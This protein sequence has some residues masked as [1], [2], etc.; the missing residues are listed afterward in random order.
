MITFFFNVKI[1]HIFTLI[2]T[3][4]TLCSS[5]DSSTVEGTVSFLKSNGKRHL[6]ITTLDQNEVLIERWIRSLLRNSKINDVY[7]KFTRIS[8]HLDKNMVTKEKGIDFSR[9]SV[10]IIA[11]AI[12]SSNW[13]N[14]ID[15]LINTEIESAT[16]VFPSEL[17]HK[18]RN[19]F[20]F[21]LKS[22]NKSSYFYW[23]YPI[24]KKSS[25][26]SF[27]RVLT[28]DNI[29]QVIVDGVKFNQFGHIKEDYDLHGLKVLSTTVAWPP[30]IY[31]NEECKQQKFDPN[32]CKPYGHLVDVLN[33]ISRVAN[34][35]WECHSD[36]FD[37]YGTAP[38]SGPA[39]TSGEWGG[40]V[41]NVFR[42]EYHFSMSTWVWNEE[43]QDMFD[44]ATIL[45]DQP[46][47]A[48]T[49]KEQNID[50]TLFTRPFSR[51][52]WLIIGLTITLLLSILFIPLM[53]S[54]KFEKSN[55]YRLIQSIAFLFFMLIEIYYGGAL[56]MFFASSPV[57]PFKTISDVIRGYPGWQ[58][59]ML[60]GN[61][62]YYVY[63]V[64][65]GDPDY[66]AFWERVKNKPEDTVVNSIDEGMN[67][68]LNGFNVVHATEGVIKGW[69]TNNAEKGKKI[70]LFGRG[71]PSFYT[72]ITTNNSPLSRI[73]GSATSKLIEYGVMNR[74]SAKWLGKKKSHIIMDLDSAFMS[75]KP[76]Q[77][78]LMYCLVLIGTI[79]TFIAVAIEQIW[80]TLK[81]KNASVIVTKTLTKFI[82]KKVRRK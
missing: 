38:I 53:I 25:V 13:N 63:K 29:Y 31:L 42:G 24:D 36:P 49:M 60:S 72:L 73:F 45:T 30:Y 6:V 32:K 52:A 47:L 82:T 18:N 12:D 1:S 35:T 74:I 54:S 69:M 71:R 65:E 68:V 3:T 50:Y 46:V 61:D 79:L 9:D 40:V 59:I 77:M 23:I 75:L 4:L 51:G 8:Q 26:I 5:I 81:Q 2:I 64:Q 44:F 15:L 27:N 48:I 22:K 39:N 16:I 57:I 34:L 43:R 10:V 78:I 7:S 66:K 76:G 55:C 37:N 19:L 56:T 11:S 62:V 67:K 33:A 28:L 21:Q 17:S 58:L 80:I 14:Y 70:K 20:L 41:G